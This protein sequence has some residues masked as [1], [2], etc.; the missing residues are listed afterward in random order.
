MRKPPA[1][2]IIIPLMAAASIIF[3]LPKKSAYLD[4][5]LAGLAWIES[6]AVEADNGGSLHPNVPDEAG[7]PLTDI[8]L[9]HG[10]PGRVHAF[11]QAAMA[12]EDPKWEAA[13]RRALDGLDEGLAAFAE[14]GYRD[15][16]LYTGLAGIAA[17]F[18]QAARVLPDGERYLERGLTLA[19]TIVSWSSRAGEGATWTG[20]TDL[21]SG[22]AGT[23]LLL[24]E[25]FEMGGRRAHLDAAMH[26]AL[27]LLTI[28]IQDENG[29]L[30]WEIADTVGL[31]YPNFS[32]GTAGVTFFLGRAARFATAIGFHEEANRFAAA[33]KAGISWLE[34]SGEAEGCVVFHHEGDGEELQYHGWCHGP[35]GTGRLWMQESVLTSAGADT[36]EY[37]LGP[38]ESGARFLIDSGLEPGESPSGYWNNLGVCC[39]TAGI[40]NY[41]LDLYLLT[42]E[43]EWLEGAKECGDIVMSRAVRAGEEMVSWP[44]AEHRTRPDFI[45]T[46]TGYMQG[47]AGISASLIRLWLVVKGRDDEIVRFPDE[48][49]IR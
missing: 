27:W 11:L 15:A 13:A 7:S 38:A 34:A 39:G 12:S 36:E 40:L 19:D 9:Y 26:A 29:H 47:A 45:Q 3:V 14:T 37:V 32:H 6:H 8:S 21:I 33:R 35:A 41:L 10:Q 24:L 4:T 22:A 18:F 25:A 30:H 31:H 17:A 44:V 5:A 42:G 46:Q 2:E 49:V 23:G 16:G 20:V 28:A 1:L 48:P 43:R